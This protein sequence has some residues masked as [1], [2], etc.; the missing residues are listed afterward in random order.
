MV[1]QRRGCSPKGKSVRRESSVATIDALILRPAFAQAVPH[2]GRVRRI[3]ELIH[4][5][6]SSFAGIFGPSAMK[7]AV[8]KSRE[9]QA[10]VTN[11]RQV[12]AGRQIASV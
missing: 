8:S 12:A 2:A 3:D 10:F 11:L 1:L 7:F 4:T 5:F 6:T 9:M